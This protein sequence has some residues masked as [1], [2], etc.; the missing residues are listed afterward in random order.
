MLDYEQRCHQVVVVQ[1]LGDLG[2][3]AEQLVRA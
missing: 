3:V 1:T 2:S